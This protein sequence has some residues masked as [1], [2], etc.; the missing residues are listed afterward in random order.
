MRPPSCHEQNK[1]WQEVVA[2]PVTYRWSFFPFFGVYYSIKWCLSVLIFPFHVRRTIAVL[3]S[4]GQVGH[5]ALPTAFS[6]C[7]K[8]HTH[9]WILA[10]NKD[11]DRCFSWELSLL[12]LFFF[13]LLLCNIDIV[14]IYNIR[15]FIVKSAKRIVTFISYLYVISCSSGITDIQSE[16]YNYGRL[17]NLSNQDSSFYREGT[18]DLES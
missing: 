1:Q 6:C 7:F 8:S 9:C 14:F 13:L 18:R 3:P 2:L 5:P 10:R 15:S 11:Q 16:F 4:Q 17:E 12:L